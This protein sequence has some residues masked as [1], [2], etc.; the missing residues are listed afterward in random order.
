VLRPALASKNGG[1]AAGERHLRDRLQL[2]GVPKGSPHP[3]PALG[4]AHAQHSNAAIQAFTDVG[5]ELA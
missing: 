3:H 1:Q 2:P 4:S 5:K